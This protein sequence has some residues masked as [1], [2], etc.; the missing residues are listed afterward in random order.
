[1]QTPFI[2]VLSILATILITILVLFVIEP[3][4]FTKEVIPQQPIPLLGTQTP[5][6]TFHWP[7]AVAVN[8]TGDIFVA[9]TQNNRIQIFNPSGGT[10]GTFGFPDNN[11]DDASLNQPYGIHINGTNFIF[12]ADTFTNVIK[13]FSPGGTYLSTIGIAGTESGEYYYPSGVATNSTHIFIADTYNNRIQITDLSG[14]TV[15]TI[16]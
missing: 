7:R 15:D 14:N 11:P 6:G 4:I 2:F 12:V 8:S 5:I 3:D 1:M 9:D 16:P 13:V 10:N